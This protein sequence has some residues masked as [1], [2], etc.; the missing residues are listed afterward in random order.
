MVH[1]RRK[2]IH[3]VVSFPDPLLIAAD[4]LGQSFE[5]KIGPV[6]TRMT[7]PQFDGN[8][9]GWPQLRFAASESNP[10]HPLVGGIDDWGNRF[11]DS[12]ELYGALVTFLVTPGVHPRDT[13]EVA[14][15][16]ESFSP[17]FLA[18]RRWVLGK[19][20]T[21]ASGARRSHQI[22]IQGVLPDGSRWGAGGGSTVMI[23]PGRRGVTSLELDA[24]FHRASA[25]EALP[26]QH[27][28]LLDAHTALFSGD[29][30]RAVVDSATAA[31]VVLAQWIQRCLEERGLAPG[32]ALS[33]TDEANGIA[34]L[35]RLSSALGLRVTPSKNQVIDRIARPRN[36]AVH[37]GEEPTHETARKAF[38]C[39]Q[40]IVEEVAPLQLP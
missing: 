31:E 12:W 27:D 30:R 36:L 33:V 16:T 32:E 20:G 17:W 14:K 37:I 35:Y 7:F 8:D 10:L 13:A 6:N 21:P 24:A 40:T 2:R 5:A 23:T 22:S 38:N 18:A 9:D 28:L 19:L 29:L 26:I 1:V 25:G 34:E 11:N 3:V 15:F 4:A 39:A